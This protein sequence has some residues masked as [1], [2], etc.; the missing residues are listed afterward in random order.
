[1]S[2]PFLFTLTHFDE[3]DADRVAASL[4]L[5][6][7]ALAVDNDVTLWLTLDGV[8]LA[9]SG[10]AAELQPASFPPVS[11]L[12]DQFIEAGGKIGVCPPCG[13]THG[14]TDD[15]MV[16]GAMWMGAAAVICAASDSKTVSF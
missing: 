16:E 11:E 13:K 4:V 14:V 5:A 15:N 9:K 6:N 8:E 12:L 1:M 3:Q 10:A 2:N 7:S